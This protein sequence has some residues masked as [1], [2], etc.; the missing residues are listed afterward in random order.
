MSKEYRRGHSALICRTGHLHDQVSPCCYSAQ[1]G[2][3]QVVQAGLLQLCSSH[4]MCQALRKVLALQ[5]PVR[6]MAQATNAGLL[7][8]STG[9]GGLQ[10]LGSDLTAQAQMVSR[11]QA[12][13][14]TPSLSRGRD[15]RITLRIIC[16]HTCR[17]D[18]TCSKLQTLPQAKQMWRAGGA[19]LK[20]SSM[21]GRGD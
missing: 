13:S 19:G 6:W 12:P 4:H 18:L 15:Q 9:S 10:P 11:L 16:Q 21:R 2:M 5:C 8:G 7:L 14:V 3:R 17:G 1:L 20:P